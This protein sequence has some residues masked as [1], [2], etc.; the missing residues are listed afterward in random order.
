MYLA[1]IR[2]L[3]GFCLYIIL[4]HS[5]VWTSECVSEL[6]GLGCCGASPRSLS[7]SV[8]SFPELLALQDSQLGSPPEGSCFHQHH[9]IPLL[10]LRWP[11]PSDWAGN[12]S[13]GP[14]LKDH[15][16]STV[17]M[18]TSRCLC[19]SSMLFNSPV[20]SSCPYSITVVPLELSPTDFLHTHILLRICFWNPN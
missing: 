13:E 15:P 5:E 9:F 14:T 20:P 19:G 17:P 6:H 18:G 1:S 8:W 10:S 12:G 2:S 3:L 16:C 7:E 11:F 4:V